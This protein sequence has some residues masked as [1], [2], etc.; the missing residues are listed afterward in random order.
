MGVLM[1]HNRF[2]FPCLNL[3]L[4]GVVFNIWHKLGQYGLRSSRIV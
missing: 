3:V 2:L 4:T 1:G